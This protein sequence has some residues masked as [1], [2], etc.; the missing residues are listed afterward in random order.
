MEGRSRGALGIAG[1]RGQRKPIKDRAYRELMKDRGHLEIL[2]R[3]GGTGTPRRAEGTE[4]QQKTVVKDTLS[5][6]GTPWA[7]G[8]SALVHREVRMNRHAVRA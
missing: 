2:R 5:G 4:T 3:A 1:G 6:Q 8:A 7:W